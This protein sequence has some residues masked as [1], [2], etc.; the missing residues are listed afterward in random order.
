MVKRN[1]ALQMLA[2]ARSSQNGKDG[3][4]QK[5]VAFR[6]DSLFLHTTD[7]KQSRKISKS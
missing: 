5:T 2:G 4:N 7:R 1:A 3:K 6:V